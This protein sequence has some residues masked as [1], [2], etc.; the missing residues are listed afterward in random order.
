MDAIFSSFLE[1]QE[2]EAR[3]LARES[4]LLEVVPVGSR[5]YQH[6]LLRF[7]CKGLVETRDGVVEAEH[8][9]I[10]AYFPVHYWQRAHPVEVLTC[11]GPVN[12]FHPNIRFPF[13]CPG[14]LMPGTS[15]SDLILQCY[16]ILTYQKVTM[17]EDDALNR[18]ACAWARQNVGRFP[19]DNRPIISR[20]IPSR[21][22]MSATPTAAA[23]GETT[24]GETAPGETTPEET[25]CQETT[26]EKTTPGEATP[27]RTSL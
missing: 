16:E 24:P 1:R 27:R 13:I 18:K 23:P 2:A 19:I 12:V 6:F 25:T 21:V 14:W 10:G 11:L 3:A 20:R 15:L 22:R 8:F 9:E 7:F 26:P 17:R 5:P 4:D